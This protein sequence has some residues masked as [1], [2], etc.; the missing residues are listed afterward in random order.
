VPYSVIASAGLESE[1]TAAVLQ[2]L[3]RAREAL[4]L[5]DRTDP[6]TMILANRLIAL[7]KAGERDPQCLCDLA[8]QAIRHEPP[9]F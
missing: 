2:A 5:A 3:E 4:G 1:A 6:L 7:A 8:L 9:R